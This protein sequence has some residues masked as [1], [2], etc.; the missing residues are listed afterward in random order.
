MPIFVVRYRPGL[1]RAVDT[2]VAD[3]LCREGAFVV[4]A[5]WRL[6]IFIPRRVIVLRVPVG[7][8]LSVE[9]RPDRAA[10][11]RSVVSEDEINAARMPRGRVE[12]GANRAVGRVVAPAEGMEAGTRTW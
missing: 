12:S 2:V 9:E 5:A 3:E 10:D 4:L 11:S 7:N 8:V 6:V 1:G